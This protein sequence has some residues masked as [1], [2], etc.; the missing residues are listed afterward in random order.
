MRDALAC[1]ARCGAATLAMA[2][3][4]CATAPV[5]QIKYFS[6]AFN[7][8]NTVGQPLLDDLAVAE[9]NRAQQIAAR[10]AQGLSTVGAEQ[11]SKDDVP[12][13][14]AAGGK[15]FI[16]GFCL[17]DAGYFSELGDPPATAAL[18]GGLLVIERYADVLLVLAEGRNVEDAIGQVDALGKNVSGLLAAVGATA[19]PISAALSALK[20]LLEGAARQAN[21]TEAKRLILEGAP[22]VTRL[23][24]ALR[25]SAPE[26]FNALTDAPIARV[27]ILDQPAAVTAE[28]SRVEAYRVAVANYVVLL[29]K[30]QAAWDLTV[31]AASAPPSNGRLASLVQ[32]TS[33]L[34]ADAEA[35][36]R[37]FAV[38]RAGA[39]K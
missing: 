1:A 6:Q 37:V 29:G 27:L 38:L 18:R 15:G 7:T 26:I 24:G 31:A 19:P 35:A 8:V 22:T 14:T 39:A 21:A 10:R 12:W 9:R 5:D 11:C 16:R 17:S 28:I 36:R 4:A 32:Q 13:Q 3:S 25:Q 2:L 33:E 23:I 20:P 30:L 34:K